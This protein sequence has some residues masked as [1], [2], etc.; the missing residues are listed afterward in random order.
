METGRRYDVDDDFSL[1]DLA[2]TNGVEDVSD[3]VEHTL[4]ATYFDTVDH[5]LAAADIVVRRSTGGDD[6]GW[7]LEVPSA[8]DPE[9]RHGIRVGLGRAVR[10]V[11]KRLR[12]TVAGLTGAQPLLP[13]ATVT[14]HRTVRRLLDA[15]GV[16]LAE[17]A[18]D[19]AH[20][21]LARA[22][23]AE[24]DRLRWREIALGLVD[25]QGDVLAQLENRLA[26]AGARRSARSSR[27]H[28]LLGG[29]TVE[30]APPGRGTD[31]VSMLVQHRL[32][33]QLA[34][35]RRR[36]PLAREDLPE[37]VHTM[38]VAVRRLHSALAT[39][40]PFLDRTETDPLRE[41]LEWLADAL[42][43]ARDSEVR[44]ERLEAAIDELLE[45]RPDVEW[46]AARV[47][48]DLGASLLE[49]HERAHAALAEVFA[50]DRYAALLDRLRELVAEIPW[51]DEADQEVRGAYLE[52]VEREVRRVE[53]RLQAAQDPSLTDEG[54]AMAL[55]QARK[56]ARRARYAVEPLLSAYGGDAAALIKRLTKLQTALGQ[57]QDTVVTRSYLLEV[58]RPGHRPA[59]DRAAVRLAGA[60]IER[61]SAAAEEYE[62]RAAQAWREL[63]ETPL[64]P[65]RDTG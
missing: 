33:G 5:R 61:E 16:V 37:G 43:Q 34:E 31:P 32:S 44:R 10:T 48:A 8:V 50:S 36:E 60:L 52:R 14:T 65:V 46:D 42:G 35:L 25:G 18:D 13:V 53:R 17:V 23:S 59:L 22:N 40:R 56:A 2:G 27:I 7:H 12:G 55:H 45:A 6:E 54:R 19:S 9:S 28:E 38:R 1:P 3:A 51:S 63:S 20:A 26:R 57:H 21:V 30:P 24:Q 49:R 58:S 4:E 11:P 62:R 64:L 29:P 41:D 15:Q 39:N 47:R